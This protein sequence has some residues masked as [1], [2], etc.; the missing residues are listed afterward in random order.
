MASVMKPYGISC[1]SY[2]MVKV[3]LLTNND[4]NI[5]NEKIDHINIFVGEHTN[6]NKY[7]T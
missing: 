7:D 2:L 4:L 3:A 5:E 6:G 1:W